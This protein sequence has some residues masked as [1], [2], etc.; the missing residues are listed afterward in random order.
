V[1]TSAVVSIAGENANAVEWFRQAAPPRINRF[2]KQ[3]NFSRLLAA[4]TGYHGNLFNRFAV[5]P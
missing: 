5:H 4:K 1:S 3:N 2:K